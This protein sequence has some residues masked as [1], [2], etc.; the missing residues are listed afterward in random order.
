MTLTGPGGSGK[1]R[2]A[3]GVAQQVKD[4]FP[5][6]VYFVPLAAATTTEAMWSGIAETLGVP[7]EQRTPPQLFGHLAQ[8]AALVV[9]DN[10]EQLR[11]RRHRGGRAADPGTRT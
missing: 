4:T 10:L 8:R 1:T 11:H 2:L 3:V 7:T 9:L 5:D 6:G